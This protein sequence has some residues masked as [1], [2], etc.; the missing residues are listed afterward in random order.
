MHAAVRDR[1]LQ[2]RQVLPQRAGQRLG[3]QPEVPAKIAQ[4]ALPARPG[5]QVQGGLLQRAGREQ[6][7]DGEGRPQSRGDRPPG[8]NRPDA[9]AG[10]GDLAQRRQVDH[11]AVRVVVQQRRRCPPPV[12][13]PAGEV[14]LDD[15]RPGGPCD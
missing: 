14:I 4:M 3:P 1:E 15:E 2:A 6:V 5:H 12:R 9:Q 10:G 7:V 8:D 11:P 13:Q